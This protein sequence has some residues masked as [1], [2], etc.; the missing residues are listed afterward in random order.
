M[1]APCTHRSATT[2]RHNGRDRFTC[3]HPMV[4]RP[5]PS[6]LVVAEQ[7]RECPFVGFEEAIARYAPAN[8]EQPTPAEY[9]TRA[10]ACSPCGHRTDNYCQSS[11]GSCSLALKLTKPD[12]ACPQGFFGAIKR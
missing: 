8:R 7:C 3:T 11:G 6:E 9:A 2:T 4:A 12:F 10:A 5:S 1:L